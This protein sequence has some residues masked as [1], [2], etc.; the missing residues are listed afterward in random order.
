MAPKYSMPETLSNVWYAVAS[1]VCGIKAV[2]VVWTM[3]V[4]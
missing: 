1:Y 3:I 2:I 4:R